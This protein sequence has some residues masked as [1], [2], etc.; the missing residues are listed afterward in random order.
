MYKSIVS[1]LTHLLLR[2]EGFVVFDH[3]PKFEHARNKLAQL[4][5]EG[6]IKREV[7]IVEGGL[8][9]AE[10]ALLDMFHGMNTG[11][12]LVEIK[13]PDEALAS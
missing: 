4:L 11:K 10:Q 2:M 12:L 9:S 3:Q 5:A 1:S 13:H 8:R 7:T 6:A